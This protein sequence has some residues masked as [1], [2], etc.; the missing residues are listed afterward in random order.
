MSGADQ[1]AGQGDGL[2]T[3]TADGDCLEIGKSYVRATSSSSGES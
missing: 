2:G 1:E 3:R